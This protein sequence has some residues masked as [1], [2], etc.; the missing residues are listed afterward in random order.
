MPELL[1]LLLPLAAL[2]GYIMGRNSYRQAQLKQHEKINQD[3]LS[4]LNLLLNNQRDKA[5]NVL[6][7]NL[8]VNN[9]TFTTHIALGKLF[10]AKGENDRAIKIH[11]FLAKQD[12]LTP[13]QRRESIIQLARDY[14]DCALYDRAEQLLLPLLSEE[15]CD[16]E[17]RV[18]LSQIY[19]VFKDWQK[20]FDA[21][22]PLEPKDGEACDTTK[23]YLLCEIASSETS[24]ATK[25]GMLHQAIQ[26]KNDCARAYL[27]LIDHYLLNQQIDHAQDLCH[28]FAK[29]CASYIA[30]LIPILEKVF[31]DENQRLAFLLEVS[32]SIKSSSVTAAISQIYEKQ[33][34]NTEARKSVLA[35]LEKHATISGFA[36][37]L[38][39]NANKIDSSDSRQMMLNLEKMV[40]TK[41]QQLP[42]YECDQCGYQGSLLFWQCPR[43]KHWGSVKPIIGLTGD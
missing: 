7:E 13:E 42:N 30:L 34:K 25:L 27:D 8:E 4:G 26:Y 38:K 32:S 11:Q 39:L 3:F 20:A 19:Q 17:A 43:C 37:L 22:E 9:E 31:T 16:R 5:I 23:A 12:V 10:R 21:I 28:K 15:K 33:N 36:N 1:F 41:I 40:V 2:Y 24:D 29:N 14:I 6:I 35:T 18:M